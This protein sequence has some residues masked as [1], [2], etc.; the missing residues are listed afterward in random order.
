MAAG[1]FLEFSR[2]LK[3]AHDTASESDLKNWWELRLSLVFIGSI[4]SR[5]PEGP[6]KLTSIKAE[7]ARRL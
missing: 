7:R 2:D 3:Y 6:E 5:T 1:V 4:L